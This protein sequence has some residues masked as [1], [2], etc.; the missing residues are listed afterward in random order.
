M[1]CFKIG[2]MRGGRVLVEDSPENLIRDYGLPSLED[3]FLQVSLKDGSRSSDKQLAEDVTSSN[4]AAPVETQEPQPSESSAEASNQIGKRTP[5]E[6]GDKIKSVARKRKS[7]NWKSSLPT[8]HFI[9]VLLRK[10]ALVM[11]RNFGYIEF[12]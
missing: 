2:M 9:G 8:P 5:N 4:E 10:N 7:F 1:L 3:V 12:A 11:I 6:K